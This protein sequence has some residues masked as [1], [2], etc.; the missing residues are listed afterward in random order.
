MNAEQL[1]RKTMPFCMAKCALGGVMVLIMGLLL[2][3]FAGIGW[4]FGDTGLF[5]GFLIWC[6]SIKYVH[7]LIMNYVGYL[8]KAG[9]I[10]V[11]AEAAATGRVPSNQVEYGKEL[12]KERFVT[13]NV[14]LALDKLIAG[15]VKQ[16]QR[17]IEKASNYLDFIPGMDKAASLV[18]WFVELSLGYIDECCLG[19]T[20]YQSQQGAFQSACDG[21]VIY[22]QNVKHLLKN[23]AMT[24]LKLILATLAAVLVIFIPV[25]VLFKLLRWSG[26]F[27]FVLACLIHGWSSSLSWTA[28]CSVRRWR[29]IWLLRPPRKSPLIC[30]AV[31][32][33]FPPASRRCGKKQRLKAATVHSPIILR[34]PMTRPLTKRLHI[35]QAHTKRLHTKRLSMMKSV[36][37]CLPYTKR[38]KS[39][40]PRLAVQEANSAET[41][42]QKTKALRA[43]AVPAAQNCNQSCM[44]GG[45][46]WRTLA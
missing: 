10:A 36:K 11:L 33:A 16:I 13:A 6:G 7:L 19:Y 31:S 14:Y 20:F 21:V 3:I 26:L 43:S 9:H 39:R 12:V 32:A 45:S 8:F 18:K 40:R 5:I 41:A 44:N 2:A 28:M 17:K 42:A 46:L 22:A 25:G 4:L 23:A 24:M 35:K 34:P 15:A 30:T 37:K 38:R 1:F 29:A 27:A